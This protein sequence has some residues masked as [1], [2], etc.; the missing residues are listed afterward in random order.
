VQQFG[1]AFSQ[2]NSGPCG[3]A[4]HWQHC[5]S[6]CSP[7]HDA[8][9]VLNCA[10]VAIRLFHSNYSERAATAPCFS[11]CPTSER[12]AHA[13]HAL[14]IFRALASH[15]HGHGPCRLG[16][17]MNRLL[18]TRQPA[19]DG[20]KAKEALHNGRPDVLLPNCICPL[21]W[22]QHVLETFG[23]SRW[24]HSQ[25]RP[26]LENMGKHGLPQW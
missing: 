19:H 24:P 25:P 20:T 26:S 18:V 6:L 2:H 10:L 22:V 16:C 15:A 5:C 3:T 23:Q 14:L 7:L 9:I 8:L 13:G 12:S 21:R 1:V 17:P 11:D 4:L